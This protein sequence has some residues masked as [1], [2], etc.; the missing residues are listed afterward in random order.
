MPLA[1]FVLVGGTSA[2]MGRNKALLRVQQ[3]TL[4]SRIAR[5]VCDVAS[6]VTLVGPERP[7]AGLGY[8]VVEDRY[9]DAGPLGGLATALAVS[10]APWVFVH[11]CDLPCVPAT[12]YGQLA[13]LVASTS[14]LAIVPEPEPEACEPLCALYHVACLPVVEEA[15]RQRRLRARDLLQRIPVERVTAC[16]PAWFANL[17]TPADWAAFSLAGGQDG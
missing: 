13:S 1:G 9:L 16:E 8:A 7:F 6:P 10:D 12:F 14:A 4:A 11:A 2:R 3:V 5:K 17:N 15:V